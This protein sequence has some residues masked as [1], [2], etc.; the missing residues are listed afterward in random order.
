MVFFSF[1]RFVWESQFTNYYFVLKELKILSLYPNP[2]THKVQI[3]T[4][5]FENFVW[6]IQ[7]SKNIILQNEAT[8]PEMFQVLFIWWY[9]LSIIYCDGALNNLVSVTFRGS[10]NNSHKIHW[11]FNTNSTKHFF[12]LSQYVL[13][14]VTSHSVYTLIW[15]IL[16]RVM[17]KMMIFIIT[18]CNLLFYI[19]ILKLCY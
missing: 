7:Y 16:W 11:Y 18:F 9:F 5:F 6:C 15:L 8:G 10:A 12:I 2:F 3:L 17:M 14:I 1:Q 13:K 19:T 4:S